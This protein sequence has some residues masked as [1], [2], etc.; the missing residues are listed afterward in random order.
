MEK[1]NLKLYPLIAVDS[2]V[3]I[4]LQRRDDS[5]HNRAKKVAKDLEKTGAIFITNNY[6]IAEALTVLLLRTKSLKASLNLGKIVYEKENP[7]FKVYE[8][9]ADLQKKAWKIFKSQKPSN[10]LSFADCTLPV[11]AKH[12]GI[13]TIFSFD[14]KFKIFEKMGLE[15]LR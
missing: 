15:I 1:D 9:N 3:L 2:N 10:Q 4:A 11:L 7:W 13:K 14:E 8:I 6:L 5:L 12:L